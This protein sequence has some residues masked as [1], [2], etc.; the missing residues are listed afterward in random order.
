MRY[1]YSSQCVQKK[2]NHSNKL[3][4]NKDRS[5]YYN[6]CYNYNTYYYFGKTLV[7]AA[8]QAENLGGI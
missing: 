3:Q 8:H 1:I 6:Y 7:P 4:R 5:Y 2:R